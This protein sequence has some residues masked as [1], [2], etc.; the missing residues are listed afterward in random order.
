MAWHRRDDH[1]VLGRGTDGNNSQAHLMRSSQAGSSLFLLSLYNVFETIKSTNA[2]VTL[3]Q[4]P[5]PEVPAM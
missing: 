2:E 4:H 3:N 5:S 1:M